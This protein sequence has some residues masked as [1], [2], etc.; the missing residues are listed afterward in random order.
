MNGT[1][2]TAASRGYQVRGIVSPPFSG[3][4]M[5]ACPG[6]GHELSDE[7]PPNTAAR[8]PVCGRAT[9]VEPEHTEDGLRFTIERH[10]KIV[11]TS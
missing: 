3:V 11:E 2:V 9:R 10:E 1:G 7:P 8:C 5:D 4:C 6:S